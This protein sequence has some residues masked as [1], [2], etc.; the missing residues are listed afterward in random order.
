MNCDH[1]YITLFSSA[2][3]TTYPKNT[4]AAFRVHLPRPVEL[5]TDD[6]WEVGVTEI[7]WSPRNVGTFT[8]PMFVGDTISMMYCVLITPQFISVTEAR[9]MRT[10]TTP[11]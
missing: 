7:T 8:P 9:I 5:G 4:I 10:F 11:S 1:F 3:Q 2:S 6:R